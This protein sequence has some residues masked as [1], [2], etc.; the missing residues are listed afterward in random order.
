V[1]SPPRHPLIEQA[2]ADAR[3]WTAGHIIDDRPA[4]A[5]AARV[6]V[7]LGHHVPDPAPTLVAACLLHDAPELAPPDTALDTVISQRY[8][9]ETLRIIRALEVEHHALDS[10]PIIDVTDRS[11][12]LA[13]TA[14]KIVAITSLL[15]RSAASGDRHAFFSARPTL[16]RLLTHFDAFTAAGAGL[17]PQTMTTEL[18]RVVGLLHDATASVT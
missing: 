12:L 6:A 2:L 17:V 8:G 9:D 5:H 16:V 11:T 18:H 3:A 10:H 13:S 4:L 7:T 1:L 15:R 14:D